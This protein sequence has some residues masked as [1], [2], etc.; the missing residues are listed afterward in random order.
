MTSFKRISIASLASL[1]VVAAGAMAQTSTPVVSSLV[2]W[3]FSPVAIAYAQSTTHPQVRQDTMKRVMASL[4]GR[5]I[6]DCLIDPKSTSFGIQVPKFFEGTDELGRPIPGEAVLTY[7]HT[8]DKLLIRA[9]K[10]VPVPR[11]PK[12]PHDWSI[13][14]VSLTVENQVNKVS[15]RVDVEVR[16]LNVTPGRI[17]AGLHGTLPEFSPHPL[18]DDIKIGMSQDDLYCMKGFPDHTNTDALGDDQEIY[19]GGSLLVYI[20]SRTGHVTDVQSSY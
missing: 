17:L 13:V 20:D 8:G 6:Y 3:T 10:G 2:G 7:F 19:S 4:V 1:L 12:F 16:A 11:D 18:S 5:P 15:A 9:A 14:T